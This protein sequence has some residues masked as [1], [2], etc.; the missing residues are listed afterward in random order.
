MLTSYQLVFSALL[1]CD[2]IVN[3]MCAFLYIFKQLQL[4]SEL[5]RGMVSDRS[6]H[7]RC[8]MLYRC[9]FGDQA[10][11]SMCV[12]TLPVCILVVFMRSVKFPFLC[13]TLPSFQTLP[14][15]LF[16]VDHAPFP[17]PFH[18]GGVKKHCCSRSCHASWHF[19][20][21]CH[22]C[23]T[24]FEINWST[25]SSINACP[26]IKFRLIRTKCYYYFFI[27]GILI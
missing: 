4:S 25:L 20:F 23:E 6:I 3:K 24:P 11:L 7:K 22:P 16:T 13:K 5:S 9:W 1:Y 2:R 18:I 8:V 17:N 27:A 19:K 10:W 15:Q 26:I 12:F 14:S 21:C